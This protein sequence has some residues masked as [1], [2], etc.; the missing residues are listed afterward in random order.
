M[1]NFFSGG[2]WHSPSPLF[3]IFLTSEIEEERE[4]E[5]ETQEKEREMGCHSWLVEQNIY[6]ITA[7]SVNILIDTL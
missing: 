4:G 1:V 3:Y 6:V 7:K 2:G 5:R